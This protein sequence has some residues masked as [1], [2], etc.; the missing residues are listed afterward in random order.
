MET[1]NHKIDIIAESDNASHQRD[2]Q[3]VK[4]LIMAQTDYIDSLEKNNKTDAV[5]KCLKELT[6]EVNNINSNNNTKQIQKLFAK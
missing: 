4:D 3:D 6:I 1:L 5:K 2:F